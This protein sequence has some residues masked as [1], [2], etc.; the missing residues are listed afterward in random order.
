MSIDTSHYPQL[1]SYF[2]FFFNYN[3]EQWVLENISPRIIVQGQGTI[4]LI[5]LLH[6]IMGILKGCEIIGSLSNHISSNQR[7]LLCYC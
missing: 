4:L 2:L 5:S 1:A 3:I 6:F 7:I